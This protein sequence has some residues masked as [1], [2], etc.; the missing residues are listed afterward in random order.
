MVEIEGRVFG[1]GELVDADLVYAWAEEGLVRYA[2][3]SFRERF[4][5][6]G[7]AFLA[8]DPEGPT[9][10]QFVVVPLSA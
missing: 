5:S 2:P 7:L 6:G 10:G 4:E 9:E 3:R 8:T 1:L